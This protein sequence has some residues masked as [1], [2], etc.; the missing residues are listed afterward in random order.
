MAPHLILWWKQD[1]ARN[2]FIYTNFVVGLISSVF[3]T[4]AVYQLQFIGSL[5]G[6]DLQGAPCTTY[7]IIPFGRQRLDLNSVL[8]YMN[9]LTLGLSGSITILIIAYADFWSKLCSTQGG[10]FSG[11]L[12]C[13]TQNTRLI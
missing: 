11:R 12:T 9:A 4:Y 10:I 3:G 7:C 5:I 1:T 6:T 13:S 8:L 2:T